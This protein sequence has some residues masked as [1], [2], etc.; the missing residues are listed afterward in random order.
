VLLSRSN[1]TEELDLAPIHLLEILSNNARAM[2]GD[3]GRISS[4]ARD[5]HGLG[6]GNQRDD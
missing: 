6:I 1:E 4:D 2:T 3:L 5:P